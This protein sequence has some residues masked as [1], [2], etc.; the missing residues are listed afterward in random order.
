MF[1]IVFID[2]FSLDTQQKLVGFTQVRLVPAETPIELDELT[3]DM[4]V[5]VFSCMNTQ[6]DEAW[7]MARVKVIKL[8]LCIFIKRFHEPVFTEN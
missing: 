3:V 4:D 7:R 6:N 1:F 2:S 8:L 5:E